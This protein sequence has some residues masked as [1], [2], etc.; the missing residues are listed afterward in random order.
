[1]YEAFIQLENVHGDLA[2]LVTATKLVEKEQEK[3]TR[4]REKAAQEQSEQYQLAIPAPINPEAAVPTDSAPDNR[5]VDDASGIP[6]PV[7]VN[8]GVDDGGSRNAR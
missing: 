1:V 3:V 2:G 7:P 5:P 4:R 6:V 8:S